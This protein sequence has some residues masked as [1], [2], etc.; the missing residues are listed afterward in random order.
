MH[1]R[2]GGLMQFYGGF[3]ANLTGR[4]AYLAIRNSL[5]KIIYDYTKPAKAFNDLTTY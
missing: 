2:G 4:L 1:G 5:Y 3:E